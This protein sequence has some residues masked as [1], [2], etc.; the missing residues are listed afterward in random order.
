MAELESK[1]QAKKQTIV[2]ID[3][4]R[5]AVS[6][7]RKADRHEA[8]AKRRLT[9]PSGQVSGGLE[10][11]KNALTAAHLI[12]A[13]SSEGEL[14][15]ALATLSSAL[16]ET[17]GPLT[18][19]LLSTGVMGAVT[20]LLS[21]PHDAVQFEIL[22]IMT[23]IAAGEYEHARTVLEALPSLVA[24]L[25]C[26]N[27]ALSEQACWVLGNLAADNDEFRCAVIVAGTCY[28]IAAI[29]KA[30]A[31]S[32]S[33]VASTSSPSSSHLCTATWCIS[34]VSR[35]GNSQLGKPFVE[36]G[37]PS[38]LLKLL[39][40][41]DVVVATEAAWALTF[42]TASDEMSSNLMTHGAASTFGEALERS[43][44][45]SSSS[46]LAC[47]V[48]RSIGNLVAIGEEYAESMLSIPSVLASLATIFVVG[49]D[50]S[51]R[52][53]VKEATWVVSNL[54][55]GPLS[56]K[57]AVASSGL[58]VPIAALLRNGEFVLQREALFAL[59]NTVLV[60][61][62]VQ[63]SALIAGLL[64]LDIVTSCVALLQAS[65]HD[66][67]LA[68]L[69][70]LEGVLHHAPHAPRLVEE[71]GGL[72]A[73]DDLS[74]SCHTDDIKVAAARLV[75][76]F[77]GDEYGEDTYPAEEGGGGGAAAAGGGLSAQ[78][79]PTTALFGGQLPTQGAGRGRQ[80][81]LPSWMSS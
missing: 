10:Y 67:V 2:K 72:E 7:V 54:S 49:R 60:G 51:T 68:S 57:N 16:S 12:M 59:A 77:Y 1:R 37:L 21:T 52:S 44:G 19:E 25:S 27:N 63:E 81:T 47:P 50:R 74:F 26:G 62:G 6:G 56:H 46:S 58:I 69:A 53:L 33:E 29:L 38:T 45:T 70:L 13:P 35:P 64:E 24:L 8:V 9:I 17:E 78:L 42:A 40:H 23:N 79:G 31:E 22:R 3:Q 55:A 15:G 18:A 34:N 20:R 76:A 5:K 75:D 11:H 48:L 73:L 14:L 65:D 39:S 71:A 28:P 66:L 36:L 61:R 80:M 32:C 43:C 30:G 41:P 4:R